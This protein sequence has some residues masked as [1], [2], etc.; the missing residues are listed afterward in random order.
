MQSLTTGLVE[1][2]E[3]KEAVRALNESLKALSIRTWLDEEQLVPGRPWQDELEA[4]IANIRSA[5]VCV[6]PSGRGPWQQV[7]LRA[8]I[9][10]FVR[11]SLPVIPVILPTCKTIPELPVFLRQFMWVDLR[12][13]RPDPLQMLKWGITGRKGF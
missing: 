6:G 10:E 13:E 12:K 11:R 8:F 3:E 5:I 9:Q 4:Q 7:E 2:S 1:N